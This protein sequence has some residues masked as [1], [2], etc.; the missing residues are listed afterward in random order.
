LN[1]GGC[2][3]DWLQDQLIIFMALAEGTSEI[4]TGSLTQHTQTAI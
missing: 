3:D 1:D 2:V 4:L